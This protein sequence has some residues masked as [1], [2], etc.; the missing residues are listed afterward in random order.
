MAAGVEGTANLNTTERTV[1]QIASVFTCERNSLGNTLV[2]NGGT[3]F[4]KTV[5]IGFAGTV[6]ASL[7]RIIEKPVH[8]I[9]VI[10]VVLCSIDTSLGGD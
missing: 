1:R 4:R 8:G 9:V 2:D 3:H 6:V 5:N 10:L 7:D